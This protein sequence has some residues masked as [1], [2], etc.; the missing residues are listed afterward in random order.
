MTAVRCTMKRRACLVALAAVVTCG[1]GDGSGAPHEAGTEAQSAGKEP[2]MVVTMLEA[3]VP[4]EREADLLREYGAVGGSLPPFIVE[5]FLLHEP[6]SDAWRIVTVWRS[7]DDLDAYRASV[8]TPEGVR[9]LRAVGSEPTL[10]VSD[11]AAH[12]AH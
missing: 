10:T 6:D 8:D 12:A 5:S 11:V 2:R 4:P 1:C 7:R 3:R 9:I